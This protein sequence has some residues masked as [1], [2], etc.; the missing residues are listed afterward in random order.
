MLKCFLLNKHASYT[1]KLSGSAFFHHAQ[2]AQMQHCSLHSSTCYGPR[3]TVHWNEMNEPYVS[4][5]F[6]KLLDKLAKHLSYHSKK[7]IIVRKVKS[8]KKSES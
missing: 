6:L 2:R 8:E 7:K 5:G 1:Q 4:S 3:V